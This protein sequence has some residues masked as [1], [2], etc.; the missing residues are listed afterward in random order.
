MI[1][2]HILRKYKQTS[3]K[4]FIHRDVAEEDK[5]DRILPAHQA[6]AYHAH[7]W[8]QWLAAPI[9]DGDW[10]GGLSLNVFPG[11]PDPNRVFLYGQRG[12][13]SPSPTL[14]Q[15]GGHP[16]CWT[17]L[18]KGRVRCPERDSILCFAAL[19]VLHEAWW[20]SKRVTKS[21]NGLLCRTALDPC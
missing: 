4:R 6:P 14:R 13:P 21:R 19:E 3:N 16:S 15:D 2:I 1:H 20:Y 12:L 7:M 8:M 11:L 18:L 5:P 10:V 9:R 17:G